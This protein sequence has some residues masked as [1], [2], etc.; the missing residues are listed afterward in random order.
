MI[1]RA[2]QYIADQLRDATDLTEE[3]VILDS[4]HS[5][6]AKK[7]RG[8]IIC[9]LKVEEEKMLKNNPNYYRVKEVGKEN[10]GIFFQ[11]PKL[12]LGLDVVFVFDFKQ[13]GTGLRFLSLVANYFHK[14][15]SF[16]KDVEAGLSNF[17]LDFQNLTIEQLN[18]VWSMGGGIHYPALFYKIR[19]I[20]L[21]QDKPKKGQNIQEIKLELKKKLKPEAQEDI[22]N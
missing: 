11:T 16:P 8:I 18:Q 19:L 13:Y 17:S 15:N 7:E 20:E 9:L 14:K 6:Q 21:E 5:L 1:E 12:L 4:L 3:E 2:L 22:D 10:D